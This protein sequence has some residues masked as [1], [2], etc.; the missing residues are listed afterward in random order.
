MLRACMGARISA[1]RCVGRC[2]DGGGLGG[3]AQGGAL[4]ARA[5]TPHPLCSPSRYAILTG[6]YASRSRRAVDMAAHRTKCGPPPC[7]LRLLLLLVVAVY[8]VPLYGIIATG[9]SNTR[10]SH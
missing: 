9:L 1:G 4:F 10:R 5:Y 3:G 2:G 7:A 6:R 8:V